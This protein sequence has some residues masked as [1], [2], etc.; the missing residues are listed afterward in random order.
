MADD[1]QGGGREERDLYLI[2]RL[3]TMRLLNG[4]SMSRL[5]QEA[6]VD[7]DTIKK[8]EKKQGVSDYIAA[9]VFAA[10]SAKLLPEYQNKE[11][12]IKKADLR[13]QHQLKAVRR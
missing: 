8:I 10:V 2:P 11:N 6:K 7:R 9:R 4:W 12:E 5:A 13:T 1:E 3:E